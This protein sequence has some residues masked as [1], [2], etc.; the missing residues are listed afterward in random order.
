MSTQNTP[1]SASRTAAQ[2]I[3]NILC[4]AGLYGAAWTGRLAWSWFLG[5][6][7]LS[8]AWITPAL[9]IQGF[10]MY[11]RAMHAP[12]P[13]DGGSAPRTGPGTR[14]DPMGDPP[15]L[16]PGVFGFMEIFRGA[17][18]RPLLITTMA[19]LM[20]GCSGGGSNLSGALDAVWKVVT[21]TC[22]GVRVATPLVDGLMDSH[23][24]AQAEPASN[25]ASTGTR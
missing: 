10:Q 21:T 4:L 9:L 1:G 16:P 25:D 13:G 11:A 12:P 22:T 20:T 7:G 14:S 2:T 19:V 15:T 18:L 23:R 24:D 5:A 8:M 3:L 17:G 6:V